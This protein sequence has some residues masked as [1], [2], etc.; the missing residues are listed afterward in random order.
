MK[1]KV[2]IIA[3]IVALSYWLYSRYKNTDAA[4]TAANLVSSNNANVAV[5]GGVYGST[6]QTSQAVL[7]S[8]G[9]GGSTATG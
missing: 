3:F 4:L 7:S 5:S 9:L 2:L 8:I 6:A 1:K